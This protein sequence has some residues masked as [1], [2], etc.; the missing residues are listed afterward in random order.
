MVT[1]HDKETIDPNK[2]VPAP[3]EEWIGF[4][5][6]GT[7]AKYD[8]FRG[9]E[10][11][12]DPIKKTVDLAI[13]FR[14]SGFK[15]KIVTARVSSDRSTNTITQQVRA[16]KKWCADNLGFIPEVTAEKDYMMMALFDDRAIRV[17]RNE[18]EYTLP[19]EVHYMLED[20][21]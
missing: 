20:I 6:D 18:G 11:I 17:E 21:D 8:Q 14:D 1:T 12:G 19:I 13:R 15:I 4:D 3:W 5:L 9:D 2:Y 7:L 10:H 16:I